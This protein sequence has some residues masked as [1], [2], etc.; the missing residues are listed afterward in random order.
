MLRPLELP[1]YATA[2][3]DR[4]SVF[5][6][7]TP[8]LVEVDMGEEGRSRSFGKNLL[9]SL[10]SDGFTIGKGGWTLRASCEV[11]PTDTNL[12]FKGGWGGVVNVPRVLVHWK[13]Y[14]PDGELAHTTGSTLELGM[15]S[16]YFRGQREVSKKFKGGEQITELEF[17]W[18]LPNSNPREAIVTELLDNLVK[19]GDLHLVSSLAKFKGKYELLPILVDAAFPPVP[20][21]GAG[22]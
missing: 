20:P 13:L 4:A 18:D 16:K 12:K 8:L 3:A 2:Y 17:T 22:K 6:K 11:K 14:A 19:Q 5:D 7:Q 15:G 10:Q 21:P 9:K 1:G